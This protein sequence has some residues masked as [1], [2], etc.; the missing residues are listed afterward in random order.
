MSGVGGLLNDGPL[1]GLPG[2]ALLYAYIACFDKVTVTLDPKYYPAGELVIETERSG[3]G[4]VYIGSMTLGGRPLKK[5]RISHGEPGRRRPAGFSDCNPNANKN[6]TLCP[7][8]FKISLSSRRRPAFGG[9]LA[10]TR[11]GFADAV[12]R[13]AYRHGRPWPC[14]HGR[15]RPRSAPYSSAPRASRS[16]GTGRPGYH[17]SDD[18]HRF[19]PHT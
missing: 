12:C 1:P 3:A 8:E 4:D 10:G 2:G 7:Y 9:L 19:Q 11:T 13:H 18:G 17:I 14:I 15:Q 16:R 5:Y 6:N